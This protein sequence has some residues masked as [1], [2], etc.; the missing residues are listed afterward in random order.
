MNI[1]P[2]NIN[3]T[4]DSVVAD[5]VDGNHMIIITPS[6]GSVDGRKTE[7]TMQRGDGSY[8]M[9]VNKYGNQFGNNVAKVRKAEESNK[10]SVNMGDYDIDALSPNKE[11]IFIFENSKI[12][13]ELSGSYRIT[14]NM[15][16]FVK[17]G[18]EFA[19]SCDCE[20]KKKGK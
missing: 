10:I 6:T 15:T 2:N 19:I 11:F 5:Q 12:N 18:E 16:Y 13:N 9:M 4:S 1:N 7:G 20:F 3:V 17:Q 14:K 8:K